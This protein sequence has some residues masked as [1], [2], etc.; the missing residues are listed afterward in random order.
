MVLTVSLC[1][2]V[3]LALAAALRR[4]AVGDCALLATSVPSS[5]VPRQAVPANKQK[6]VRI[7]IPK[8]RKPLVQVQKMTTN[9][10]AR[11]LIAC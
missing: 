3:S 7:Q 6:M 4:S 10:G 5:L 8:T 11:I 1:S 2:S 9:V